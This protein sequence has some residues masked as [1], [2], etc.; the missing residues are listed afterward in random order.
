MNEIRSSVE[1]GSPVARR[2]VIKGLAGTSLAATPL[3]AILADSRKA[4][5]AAATT[6]DVTLTTAGGRTVHGALAL[7]ESGS[8]PA[9]LLIHEWW[10]LNDQ[11]K[12]VAADF[13]RQG[14]VALAVDLYGGEVATTKDQAKALMQALDPAEATD[15]L[16]SWIDWLKMHEAVAKGDGPAG[17]V[18]TVGTIGWC[19]GGGWS[20]NASVATPVDAT[21]IYYGRVDKDQETLSRLKGPVLGH[22]A[23]KDGWINHDMVDPFAEKLTALNHPHEIHWYDADHAFA[24]PTGERFD[25]ADAQQAWQR[26]LD[27]LSKTLKA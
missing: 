4:E 25:E 11:I 19:L 8:G 6:T 17:P 22:F 15:T 14:Y 3:A 23:E 12:S 10:G 27:F 21:V 24:N 20:L 13:A 2:T 5:A 18:G 7:P 26:T 1:A 16:V 9:M